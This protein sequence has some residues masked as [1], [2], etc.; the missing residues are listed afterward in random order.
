MINRLIIG[1]ILLLLF[2]VK[3]QEI[4]FSEINQ[5]IKKQEYEKSINALTILEKKHPESFDVKFKLAQVYLWNANE[6]KAY[7]IVS[8]LPSD[9][10]NEDLLKLKIN[11]QQK[12]KMFKDV[13]LLSDEG[14]A[15]YPDKDFYYLQKAQ[16]YKSLDEDSLALATLELIETNAS[17]TSTI[18]YLKK[19]IFDKKKNFIILGYL[20]TNSISDN[21]PTWHLSALEY[22][23]KFKKHTVIGR[24]N[25]SKLSDIN[26]VQF[27]ADWYPKIS[28]KHYA[29]VNFGISN[30]VLFP[31]YKITG[32]LFREDKKI[33]ASLG[34]KRLIFDELNIN[35]FT[36]HFG[37]LFDT[38]K[39]SYRNFY[40]VQDNQDGVFS[41]ML[42]F[43]KK[44]DEKDTYIQ[45]ELIYGSAPYFF[46]T[47]ENFSRLS[48]YRIGIVSRFKI[49]NTLS[50]Q[51]I[52][53]YEREEILPETFR[54]RINIQANLIYVF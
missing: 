41:H 27:E 34:G 6:E 18:V 15:S 37:Y 29:L 11:I 31:K 44:F 14:I 12:R 16:A 10:T 40:I 25:Y 32:E 19:E 39:V 42:S 9:I 2:S 4:N 17:N 54:E 53:Q 24:I 49:T 22:G 13:L 1:V 45:L 50:F 43:Q 48:N 52:I 7:E 33:S 5:W 8:S 21:F 35:I 20:N 46:Y 51:P 36:G 47:T 26:A 30:D 28:K 3:A 38:Y 23:H